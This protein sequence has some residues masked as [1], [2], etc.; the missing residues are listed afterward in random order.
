MLFTQYGIILLKIWC[1]FK[2]VIHKLINM[3]KYS[4]LLGSTSVLQWSVLVNLNNPMNFG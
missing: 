3:L 1:M 2:N 4:N